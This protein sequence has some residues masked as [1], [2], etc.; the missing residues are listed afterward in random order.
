MQM[1]YETTL[2]NVS[3]QAAEATP[4]L[5]NID[6]EEENAELVSMDMHNI[7]LNFNEIQQVSSADEVFFDNP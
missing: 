6:H 5:T 2:L 7:D 1:N 4:S 3:C